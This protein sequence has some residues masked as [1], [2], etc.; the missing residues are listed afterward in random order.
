MKINTTIGIMT[1]LALTI[2][3]TEGRNFLVQDTV[4]VCVDTAAPMQ[5]GVAQGVASSIFA[6]IGIKLDWRHGRRCT[7]DGLTVTLTVNTPDKLMPGAWAYAQPPDGSRI[8]VFYDRVRDLHAFPAYAIPKVL[9]H[10]LAHEIGHALQGGGRH[11]ATGVMKATWSAFDFE[12]MTSK[13]LQFT[14]EDVRLIRAGL[15][16]RTLN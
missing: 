14:P 11:S 16:R 13:P 12:S 7:A 6:E 1:F 15:A 5:L 2:Q 3:P 8:R 9:G 10:V 4:V